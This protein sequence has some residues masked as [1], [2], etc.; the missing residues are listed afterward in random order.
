MSETDSMVSIQHL[1]KSFGDTEV[2]KDV[3]IEVKK[4]S[5]VV[6]L[7]P[8][9]SGKSTML[10]CINLLEKPSGGHIYIEGNEITDPKTDI[11]KLREH[12]GMVFQQFNLFPHLTAKKNVMLAQ[13]KVLKRSKEEAEQIALKELARVGLAERADYLPSQLS[14]GQQQRVAIARALAMEPHV[15]LFDEA[16]SALD[17]ELVRGVLD[18]MRELAEEGMTMVVVTHEMQFAK[19]VAD[20]VIFMEGGV[21]VEEG[22]PDEVFDHPQHERTKDFLGHIS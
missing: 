20:H 15:M 22:T 6:V 10:R 13:R 8:S 4:G 11:N 14:G 1:S 17:P 3:N 16:T 7:G 5:V 9:G 12:V 18:V 21:V 19:D 2:L